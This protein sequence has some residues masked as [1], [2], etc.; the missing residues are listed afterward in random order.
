MRARGFV[1]TALIVFGLGVERLL[2]FYLLGGDTAEYP[3]RFAV[4]IAGIVLGALLLA[5]TGYT[6]LHPRR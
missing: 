5:V 4:G 1:M 3:V 2:N 6:R